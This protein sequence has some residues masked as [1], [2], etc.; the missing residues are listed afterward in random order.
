[1][2]AP[3]A[4]GERITITQLRAIGYDALDAVAHHA[5]EACRAWIRGD[6][7]RA[8]QELRRLDRAIKRY[9]EDG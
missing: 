2:S 5:R 3:R 6:E 7:D 8:A 1:M 9:Q 4:E